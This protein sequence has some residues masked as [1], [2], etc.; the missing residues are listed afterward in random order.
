MPSPQMASTSAAVSPPS[1]ARRSCSC[2]SSNFGISMDIGQLL[3]M[4]RLVQ[5]DFERGNI[6]VPL[7]QRGNGAEAP[8]RLGVEFPNRLRYPRAVVVDQD[9]HVVGG[10]MAGE[11]DFAD[12]CRR[13]RIEISNGV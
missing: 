8:E 10:V 6:C 13:Q 9:I 5:Q 4:L 2:S 12:R 11:V 7:D 3:R 1:T